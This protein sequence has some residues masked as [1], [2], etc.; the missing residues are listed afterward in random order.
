MEAKDFQNIKN[1]GDMLRRHIALKNN[2]AFINT[3]SKS[4]VSEDYPA[5]FTWRELFI[6]LCFEQML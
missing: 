5:S 3:V 4:T 2:G 6:K 1:K